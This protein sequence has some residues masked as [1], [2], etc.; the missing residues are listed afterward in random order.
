MALFP[1]GSFPVSGLLASPKYVSW[2]PE[3]KCGCALA[4]LTVPSSC[5]RILIL[6]CPTSERCAFDSV[7]QNLRA[8]LHLHATDCLPEGSL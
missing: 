4:S 5:S 8:A 3:V 7:I 1:P 6:L 2:S